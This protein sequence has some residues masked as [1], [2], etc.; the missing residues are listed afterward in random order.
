MRS[1]EKAEDKAPELVQWRGL[2]WTADFGEAQGNEV[3]QFL[4]G[5]QASGS[6]CFRFA[7]GSVAVSVYPAKSCVGV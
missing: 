3:G 4:G 2:D 7:V 5:A 6:I 1:L